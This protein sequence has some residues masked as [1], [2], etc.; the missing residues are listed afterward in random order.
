MQIL[1]ET[2]IPRDLALRHKAIENRYL[3]YL[4]LTVVLTARCALTVEPLGVVL[5]RSESGTGAH[6][7][8]DGGITAGEIH[9]GG[10]V[11]IPISRHQESR[12]MMGRIRTHRLT[13]QLV[14][15][16]A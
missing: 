6:D 12:V 2:Q 14:F 8:V 3:I 13:V 5:R 11:V 1:A 16:V 7:A 4:P 10:A 15:L 9:G